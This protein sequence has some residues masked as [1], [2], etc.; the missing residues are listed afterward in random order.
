MWTICNYVARWNTKIVDYLEE[1][2]SEVQEPINRDSSLDLL[3]NV[4][5]KAVKEQQKPINRLRAQGKV[6]RF[7]L[8][9]P[10]SLIRI[11]FEYAYDGIANTRVGRE[12]AA[13]RDVAIETTKENTAKAVSFCLKSE[14]FNKGYKELRRMGN[15]WCCVRSWRPRPV[16]GDEPCVIIMSAKEVRESVANRGW[17]KVVEIV[18]RTPPFLMPVGRMIAYPFKCAANFA[19]KQYRKTHLDWPLLPQLP[20]VPD[21]LRDDGKGDYLTPAERLDRAIMMKMGID[22]DGEEPKPETLLKASSLRN[23]GPALFTNALSQD[24]GFA[25]DLAMF[26]ILKNTTQERIAFI[27]AIEGM[28][29]RATINPLW[30]IIEPK[31]TKAIA[32]EITKRVTPLALLALPTSVGDFC[33]SLSPLGYAD[34]INDA[35]SLNGYLFKEGI[36]I[37]TSPLSA[38]AGNDVISYIPGVASGTD[39]MLGGVQGVAGFVTKFGTKM[40]LQHGTEFG[41]AARHVMTH[42]SNYETVGTEQLQSLGMMKSKP[43]EQRGHEYISGMLVGTLMSQFGQ[44]LESEAFQGKSGIETSKHFL[45]AVVEAISRRREQRP[46]A[47]AA[48]SAHAAA[49]AAPAAATPSPLEQFAGFDLAASTFDALQAKIMASLQDSF[50]EELQRQRNSVSDVLQKTEDGLTQR[51]AA[52]GQKAEGLTGGLVSSSTVQSV[53]WMPWTAVSSVARAPA[54]VASLFSSSKSKEG[55]KED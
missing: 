35:G 29:L 25:K 19:D 37:T 44:M 27:E 16:S 38:L 45:S 26:K 1:P 15:K 36:R 3:S 51:I 4:V 21:S 48:A 22:L 8:S 39:L 50:T 31:I 9:I 33:S 7:V 43:E 52:V 46:A 32:L 10:S 53:L 6:I 18:D 28:M 17:V 40:I 13:T 12:I 23:I 34:L 42:L 54:A 30:K 20:S 49:T 14:R 24:A 41:P 47:A 2:V 55:L 5:E 11:P